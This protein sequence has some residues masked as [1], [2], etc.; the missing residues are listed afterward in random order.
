MSMNFNKSNPTVAPK[1]NH[2]KK[3]AEIIIVVVLGTIGA[4]GLIHEV[5]KTQTNIQ[6]IS[7]PPP[8]H[9]E[10]KLFSKCK[11][12]QDYYN[13]IGVQ[14]DYHCEQYAKAYSGLVK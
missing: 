7:D 1:K 3:I 5:Q 8:S 11:N 12:L 6:S 2:N 4:I 10:Q 9:L 14:S 13:S